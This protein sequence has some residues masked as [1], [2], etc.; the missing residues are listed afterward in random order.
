MDEKESVSA[1]SV[2]SFKGK[3]QKLHTDGVIS[4]AV[5]VYMTHRTEL[6]LW[7]ALTASNW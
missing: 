6:N 1:V 3:L 4:T 7:E 5:Q 2:S